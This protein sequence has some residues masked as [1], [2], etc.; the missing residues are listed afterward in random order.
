MCAN[1]QSSTCL[2]PPSAGIKVMEL[3]ALYTIGN[4]TQGPVHSRQVLYHDT[5]SL[6]L[7]LFCREPFSAITITEWHRGPA[8][9][10]SA[11]YLIR[12]AQSP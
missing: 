5:A 7:V 10:E 1:S 11:L 4:G 2:C 12:H 6:A 9:F 3:K 8:G